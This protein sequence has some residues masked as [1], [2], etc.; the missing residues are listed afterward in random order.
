MDPLQD[1][2]LRIAGKTIDGTLVE[3]VEVPGHPWF[4][5]CQFHPEFTSTPRDAIRC[6]GGSSR[7]RTIIVS[8]SA[9]TS[10][11]ELV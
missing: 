10:A 1:A 5:G 8:A 4:I 9:G 6:S 3:V 2:G 11:N 7:R